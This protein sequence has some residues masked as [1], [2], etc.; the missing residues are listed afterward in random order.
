MLNS[1]MKPRSSELPP[2]VMSLSCF[3]D[4]VS[5]DKDFTKLT[6]LPSFWWDSAQLGQRKHPYVID[7]KKVSEDPQS[8]QAWFRGSSLSARK[9]SLAD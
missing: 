8:T 1:S 6:S 5:A 2:Q 9:T 7:A 3:T 4:Q